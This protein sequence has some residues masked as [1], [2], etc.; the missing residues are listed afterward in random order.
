MLLFET[1]GDETMVLAPA[2][3]QPFTEYDP[4]KTGPLILGKLGVGCPD[5]LGMKWIT[6]N[7]RRCRHGTD[8]KEA[9]TQARADSAAE[10]GLC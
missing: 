5:A 3:R 6:A 8:G 10:L 4:N 2:A 9:C 1:E 7:S